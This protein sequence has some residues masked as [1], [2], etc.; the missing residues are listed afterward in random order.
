MAEFSAVIRQYLEIKQA[1]REALVFFRLGDFYELFFDDARLAADK[2]G[3]TLTSRDTGNGKSPMC[4]VPHHAAEGYILRLVDMGYRVALAEQVGEAKKGEILRREVVR[5]YTPGTVISDTNCNANYIATAFM[6]NKRGAI[7]LAYC[8]IATGDFLTTSFDNYSKFLDE[9]HKIAPVEIV[10][11]PNFDKANEIKHSIGLT[12]T[13]YITDAFNNAAASTKLK[14]HFGVKSLD[15]FGFADTAAICAAGALLQYLSDM[16]ATTLAH[17][18]TISPYAVTDYMVLDKNARR[19]LELTESLRDKESVGSLLWVLDHTKTPM[20]KRLLHK[21]LLNPLL[22]INDIVCRH[23]AVTE[24]VADAAW[25][26]D[27]RNQL[28]SIPDLERLCAK[29][30]YRRVKLNNLAQLARAIAALGEIKRLLAQCESQLNSFFAENMDDLRDC[31]EEI[32][33]AIGDSQE[34]VSGYNGALDDLD[35]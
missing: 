1:N 17:I 30:N 33:Q 21:W 24:F 2:L 19:N 32:A 34:F 7:G 6:D 35:A 15:G 31:A 22:N 13:V 8:D 18:T 3:L 25:L 20:G 10:I 23:Q 27:I 14:S 26:A 5:I 9:L 28:A 29:I 16:Q 11:N 4:G 12:P